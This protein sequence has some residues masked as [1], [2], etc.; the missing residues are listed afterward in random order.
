M[1]ARLT[2]VLAT[3]PETGDVACV[4][5]LALAARRR[6]LAV[7]LFA[8]HRGV[9]ALAATPAAVAALHDADCDLV[10]CAT[11][12]DQHGVDLAALGVT[13]GSQDDHA[14]LTDGRHR[15]VAFT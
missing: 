2:F 8:M 7:S 13:A 9:V 5:E 15:V 11:S 1:S 12:A 14:A 3:G 4:V 10:G 6:N